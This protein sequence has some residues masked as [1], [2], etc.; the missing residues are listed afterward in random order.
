M[1]HGM[2]PFGGWGPDFGWLF[3]M[4]FWA[5]V[6]LGVIALVKWLA[7]GS[8]ARSGPPPRTPLQIL[9]ERYARGEIER[10]EFEQKK[11]DLLG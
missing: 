5:L 3:M 4:L 8:S 7:S 10:E 2:G 11:R 6:I 1:M 9:Q